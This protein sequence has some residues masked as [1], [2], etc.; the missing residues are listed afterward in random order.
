MDRRHLWRGQDLDMSP[1]QR[2]GISRTKE[3]AWRRR[4]C[5]LVEV[6]A[7]SLQVTYPPIQTAIVYLH[8]YYAVRSMERNDPLVMVAAALLL[9][10]KVEEQPKTV[11]KVVESVYSNAF[12]GRTAALHIIAKQEVS[13]QIRDHVERAERA[14][15]YS[16]GFNLEV[17]HPPQLAIEFLQSGFNTF[18]PEDTRVGPAEWKQ[19]VHKRVGEAYEVIKQL[20][21]ITWSLGM[22][23]YQIPHHLAYDPYHIAGA[24]IYLAVQT[25]RLQPP[26][27]NGWYWWEE[28]PFN[29]PFDTLQEIVS[30]LLNLQFLADNSAVASPTTAASSPVEEEHFE[31]NL[32]AMNTPGTQPRSASSIQSPQYSP[33]E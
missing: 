24:A 21:N 13:K 28:E 29:I 31:Q 30:S 8:Q 14:L 32:G 19:Q 2:D 9:A 18:L 16:L 23:S 15:L 17:A 1:S 33:T 22:L 10:C 12:R 7:R 25:L 5:R 4:Y 11:M 20:Q 27:R 3:E 26:L 6:S